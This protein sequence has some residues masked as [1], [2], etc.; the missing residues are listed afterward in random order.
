M[1]AKSSIRGTCMPAPDLVDLVEALYMRGFVP[2]CTLFCGVPDRI[3]A[4]L[5]QGL[6]TIPPAFVADSYLGGGYL[7][8]DCRGFQDILPVKDGSS[9]AAGFHDCLVLNVVE[10]DGFGCS[11]ATR[12]PRAPL[13]RRSSTLRSREFVGI[14]RLPIGSGGS[15]RSGRSPRTALRR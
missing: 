8:S 2:T 10:P 9:Y 11:F 7:S 1:S 4:V 6:P 15:T 14:W 13:F 5:K 3:A 12:S